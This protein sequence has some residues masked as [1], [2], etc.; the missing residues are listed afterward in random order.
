MLVIVL[1]HFYGGFD[2]KKGKIIRLIGGLYTVIDESG[3]RID[4]KPIG[5][6]RYQNISPKVGDDVYFNEDSITEV[7][8]R[9]NDL[10]RPAIANVDQAIIIC[11][12]KKPDFS[13]YL[14]DQ[15][16]AL[17][18]EANISPVI[19]LTKIDLLSE[20]ELSMIKSKLTYYEMFF[21]VRYIDSKN[22]VGINELMQILTGKV[23]VFSGQTGA[24]KSSL[25]NAIMPE[26]NLKTDAISEALGRGKHTTR[27]VELIN[28]HEGWIADTPGFSKLEFPEMDIARLKDLY[29]DFVE[30]SKD[31]RFN[32]C[33]HINEPD[34]AVKMAYQSGNLLK[35]R[36]ENYV[37]FHHMIKKQKIKY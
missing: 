25:L 16:L 7:L 23:S 10:I 21:P 19:V 20:K 1:N 5:L 29:P 32:G 9:K 33:L 13:F 3:I 2:L 15:F 6:F 37:L 11:S 24:G 18:I 34:C 8:P 4:I 27:H 35:E 36:Y 12:A 14:L 26:L 30:L 31:C 17:I 22:K 28:V